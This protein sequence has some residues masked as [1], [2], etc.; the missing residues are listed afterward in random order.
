MLNDRS[1]D[2]VKV[3]T[4]AGE[5]GVTRGSFYWHFES[6][7]DLLQSMLEYW[8]RE[9]TDTVIQH[10]KALEDSAENKLRDVVSNV[11]LNRQDRYDTAISAW[12]LFDKAAARTQARVA[13]KRLRFMTGL[14]CETG[15]DPQ[16][17]KFR[18]RMLYSLLVLSHESLPPISR[19]ETEE[20]IEQCM[21]LILS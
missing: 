20:Q 15:M 7:E 11:L 1:V 5:L 21:K 8:E 17:A 6:R 12:S 4:L 18:S 19:A 3:L 13:R 2:S 16:T 14:L 9:L 10:A